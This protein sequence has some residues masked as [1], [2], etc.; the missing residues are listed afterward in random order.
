MA[1]LPSLLIRRNTS[2]MVADRLREDICAGRYRDGEPLRQDDIA[3]ALGVSRSPVR[4]AL[5][6]LESEGLIEY[7][8]YRGY[9][10]A[11]ISVNE[12][13][14][15][16]EALVSLEVALLRRAVPLIDDERTR[17][18]VRILD[19]LEHPSSPAHGS[20]LDWKFHAT[21]YTP[22]GRPRQ[23]GLV[24]GLHLLLDRP[25]RFALSR[26]DQHRG[27]QTEHRALLE[28]CAAGDEE[29][30]SR[31]LREHIEGGAR[32][33]MAGVRQQG[34]AGEGSVTRVADL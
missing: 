33:I 27:S 31:I 4:D 9:V 29:Q 26:R 7:S 15:I 14:D 25:M 11:V 34:S 30:A 22:A 18:A 8:P 24:R 21:L 6:T 19:D 17:I 28:A 13:R 16:A 10:I 23:L 32:L 3:H 2:A 1:T 20:S 12:V 5:R